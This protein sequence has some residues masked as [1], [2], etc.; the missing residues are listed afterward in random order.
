MGALGS[1]FEAAAPLGLQPSWSASFI[2]ATLLITYH[3]P[4]GQHN[5]TFTEV[6]DGAQRYLIRSLVLVACLA[7]RNSFPLLRG[8]SLTPNYEQ[9]ATQ[10]PITN[11]PQF[12]VPRD[13]VGIHFIDVKNA[14]ASLIIM[15]GGSTHNYD[16]SIDSLVL[17]VLEAQSIAGDP[18]YGRI[19]YNSSFILE[20]TYTARAPLTDYRWY[21]AWLTSSSTVGIACPGSSSRNNWGEFSTVYLSLNT[22]STSPYSRFAFLAGSSI[23]NDTFQIGGTNFTPTTTS[24]TDGPTSTLTQLFG[25]QHLLMPDIALSGVLDPREWILAGNVPYFSS[26]HGSSTC[27]TLNVTPSDYSQDLSCTSR[28]LSCL[29]NQL[30]DVIQNTSLRFSTI[31]GDVPLIGAARFNLNTETSF[32]SLDVEWD[33]SAVELTSSLLFSGYE[34]LQPNISVLEEWNMTIVNG[35]QWTLSF[36]VQN[37]GS[38]AANFTLQTSCS[39]ATQGFTHTLE[40]APD[41]IV[42]Y[43]APFVLSETSPNGVIVCTASVVTESMPRWRDDKALSLPT[44]KFDLQPGSGCLV[45]DT[46]DPRLFATASEWEAADASNSTSWESLTAPSGLLGGSDPLL[47]DSSYIPL[48][49]SNFRFIQTISFSVVVYGGYDTSVVVVATCGSGSRV[50]SSSV[51]F[52]V[53]SP[54][55][56]YL[57]ETSIIMQESSTGYTV[58]CSLNVS[59][60]HTCSVALGKRLLQPFSVAVPK[61]PCSSSNFTEPYLFQNA[62]EWIKQSSSNQLNN[63]SLLSLSGPYPWVLTSDSAYWQ[64]RKVNM[65][66]AEM[67]CTWALLVPIVVPNLGN[68]SVFV[69]T[70]GLC[71]DPSTST[72]SSALSSSCLAP[73]MG[74]CTLNTIVLSNSSSPSDCTFVVKAVRPTDNTDAC[75]SGYG[76]SYNEEHKVGYLPSP[77]PPKTDDGL[78]GIGVSGSA[79]VIALLVILAVA[80]LSVTAFLVYRYKTP[81][82]SNSSRSLQS[83]L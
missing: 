39:L 82:S 61:F 32:P 30:G 41:Q 55:A 15:T 79:A 18:Y 16:P 63:L 21:A 26:G 69:S 78:L 80:I 75:W 4:P 28:P 38:L 71:Q 64:S 29:A 20:V 66:L 42:T 19:Y 76:K 24:N 60:P 36:A 56:R 77:S 44:F 2:G 25:D 62:S 73:S 72:I 59:I 40:V 45:N 68:G 54:G 3:G 10:G 49:T 35:T 65:Q 48:A 50:T 46:S 53:P 51:S 37:S 58:D 1:S 57:T 5:I 81:K 67:P 47:L 17:A 70:G 22:I 11:I 14:T 34:I 23:G 31:V 74:S 43:L 6:Q 33:E 8:T 7:P 83:D 13:F 27:N 12:E 52:S 9:Y